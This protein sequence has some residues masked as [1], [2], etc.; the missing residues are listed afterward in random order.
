MTDEQFDE[1]VKEFAF[2]SPIEEKA[3]YYSWKLSNVYRVDNRDLF[4]FLNPGNGKLIWYSD[5]LPTVTHDQVMEMLGYEKYSKFLYYINE[6][7]G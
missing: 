6:F 1:M 2:L 7:E 5:S 3:S 4:L